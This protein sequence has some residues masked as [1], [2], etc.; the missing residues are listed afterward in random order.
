M[1]SFFKVAKKLAATALSKQSPRLPIDWATSLPWTI[2]LDDAIVRVF[3]GDL[4]PSRAV[5]RIRRL[6]LRR[7]NQ[8][9]LNGGNTSVGSNMLLS[10]ATTA[11]DRPHVSVPSREQERSGLAGAQQGS[12]RRLVAS[13]HYR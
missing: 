3:S 11:Q 12:L 6:F 8:R 13:L 4:T 9:L 10:A 5:R 2:A 1:S 7:V